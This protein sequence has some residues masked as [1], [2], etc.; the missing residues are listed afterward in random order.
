MSVSQR[1]QASSSD[2]A[3]AASFHEGAIARRQLTCHWTQW[4]KILATYWYGAPSRTRTCGLLLR[5]Q[6]LYPP[7]LSGP[8]WPDGAPERAAEA[9]LSLAGNA[10][11]H[12]LGI[13]RLSTLAPA[14]IDTGLRPRSALTL[15]WSH[16][17]RPG[18]G[19]DRSSAVQ[20]RDVMTQAAV[21]ES[22]QD[23][24]RSA[25]ERMWRQQT[26]SLVITEDGRLAGIITERD[27][28]RAVALG[29]DPD[30]T[31]VDDAMTAEVYTV[32]PDMPLQ[33]AARE[34]ARAGSGTCRSWRL[35]GSSASSACA[36]L[37]A[38]SL[39]WRP[40][41]SGWSTSSTS[42][43]A[44]DG[45]PGS[46]TATSTRAAFPDCW[47]SGDHGSGHITPTVRQHQLVPP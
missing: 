13:R 40:A 8:D 47:L 32:P 27:L 38:F 14:G 26:G 23:S 4:R 46:S 7:E 39:R 42:W 36:T 29:A 43:S 1:H 25:A 31:T 12:R 22:P 28:L 30:K 19:P 6:S 41:T 20:V 35:A 11:S 9:G 45:W 3:P 17:E 18:R 21:T 33:E 44:N 24:I 10:A 2:T 5:R 34:M 15:G 16:A 37:P